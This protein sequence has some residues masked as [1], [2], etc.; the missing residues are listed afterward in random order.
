VNQKNT[1]YQK[2]ERETTKEIRE[3]RNPKT[4]D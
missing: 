4:I 2:H 3:L 1:D